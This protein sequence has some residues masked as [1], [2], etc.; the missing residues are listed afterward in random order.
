MRPLA[1]RRSAPLVGGGAPSVKSE[2]PWEACFALGRRVQ[3][4]L[5]R[6]T[7]RLRVS[8]RAG[9]SLNR[10]ARLCAA[11]AWMRGRRHSSTLSRTV[12]RPRLVIVARTPSICAEALL[13][14]VLQTASPRGISSASPLPTTVVVDRVRVSARIE[15]LDNALALT[16]TTRYVKQRPIFRSSKGIIC[17]VSLVEQFP[18]EG[19]VSILYGILQLL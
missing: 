17:Q 10:E 9:C 14:S 15:E 16:K 5:G 19:Q 18:Q 12:T 11:R 6:V 4:C 13:A 1:V 8:Q 3:R 2:W 7:R